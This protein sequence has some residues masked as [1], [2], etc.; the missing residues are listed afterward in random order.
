MRER[1][2]LKKAER[3]IEL[4]ERKWQ[5][6]GQSDIVLVAWKMRGPR[7]SRAMFYWLEDGFKHMCDG[8]MPHIDIDDCIEASLL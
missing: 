7:D 2:A 5:R 8:R 3:Y 1:D 6:Y 4:L